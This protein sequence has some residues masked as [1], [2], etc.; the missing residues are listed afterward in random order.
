MDTTT[1]FI[2]TEVMLPPK[3]RPRTAYVVLL[4]FLLAASNHL[5]AQSITIPEGNPAYH[6]LDRLEIK[7]GGTKQVY[8]TSLR[9]FLR[10]DA[11]RFALQAKKENTNLSAL[12]SADIQYLL[13]DNNEWLAMGEDFT[14]LSGKKEQSD[15]AILSKE[16]A[17]YQH[18]RKPILGVFYRTPANLYE[19][20]KKAFF[21]R[22][23][24]ILD[25]QLAKENNDTQP[26][27]TNRRGI[28]IRGGVDD[29]IYFYTNVLET[30]ARF[31]D[32]ANDRIERDGAIPGAGLFKTYTSTIFDIDRG[33]DF[34]NA[35]AYF[36]FNMTRH[37][38]VQLGHGRQ[39]VGNGYR[40]MLLSDFANNYFFLKLNWRV[41]KL[42][43]QNL[44]TELVADS[45]R[46]GDELVPKKYMAAHHLSFDILPN[47]NVGL[48][49]AVIFSR[50]NQFEL[51]YLNPVILYRTV[52]HTIGSPDNVLLGLDAKWDFLHRFQL[53]GQWLFDEF[54][55]DELLIER[56]G[57]WANKFAWQAG[58]KYIDAFGIDHLDLQAEWNGARPYM[59]TYYDSSSTYVHQ[60]QPLAH[61]LGANFK[62]RLL[63]LRYQPFKRW[64]LDTRFFLMQFGEDGPGTNWGGNILLPNT[65]Y[66]MDYGNEIGQGIGS[67]VQLLTVDIS[68][69]LFHNC[70]IDLRYFLRKQDSEDDARDHTTQFIGGG[71]RLNA[72]MSRLD[73]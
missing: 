5:A 38:G 9:P 4:L 48:Y 37:V 13:N 12:D 47:L 54:K 73:F 40:S 55:F 44:F 72:G 1:N 65:T 32:Y 64:T 21:L 28:E 45:K 6:I 11:A 50:N 51:Q 25:F 62:E 3:N 14:T 60:R 58:L 24:P 67:K 34:L 41:W 2:K 35:Q 10:S 39:F 29:R 15:L 49:E 7:S 27:F 52:E 46:Q 69:R 22:V 61:P 56:R 63:L 59:Y 66:E 19:L 8:H 17:E 43:L 42:H 53:Y 30:Q 71:I 68:Y 20:N 33:Y 16:C 23:N 18:S 70:F 36:G 31:P 26:I 57:W